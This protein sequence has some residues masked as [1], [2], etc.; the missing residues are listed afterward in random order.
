[1]RIPDVDY[2][3]WAKTLPAAA[4]DLARSSV[5]PCPSRLLGARRARLAVSDSAHDGYAPLVDALAQRYR[6]SRNRVFTVSGGASLANWIACA[7][8]LEGAHRGDEI[9]LERPTY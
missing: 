8:A 5:E 3:R 6:V 1:M 2:I 7:I 4:I 9:I